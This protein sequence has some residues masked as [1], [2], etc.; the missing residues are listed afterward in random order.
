MEL[1]CSGLLGNASP[2][3][4]LFDVSRNSWWSSALGLEFIIRIWSCRLL[5]PVPLDGRE[6][7]DSSKALLC[8]RWVS[9][10]WTPRFGLLHPFSLALWD[11]MVCLCWCFSNIHGFFT[12]GLALFVIWAKQSD[13]QRF[14]AQWGRH[15]HLSQ[16]RQVRLGHREGEELQKSHS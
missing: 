7:W 12:M 15:F 5:L 9:D 3:H 11:T 4:A 10:S 14:R 8:H 6:D 16:A 2:W 13:S 1:S